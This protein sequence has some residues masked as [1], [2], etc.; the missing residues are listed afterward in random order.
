LVE[1]HVGTGRFTRRPVI[2]AA[3]ATVKLLLGMMRVSGADPVRTLT[4]VSAET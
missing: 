4:E 2:W 3:S 1:S